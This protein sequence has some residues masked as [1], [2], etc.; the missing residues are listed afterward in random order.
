MIFGMIHSNQALIILALLTI[1]M[2]VNVRYMYSVLI[3]FY[4]FDWFPSEEITAW[5]FEFTSTPSLNQAFEE[6]DYE[7]S[8]IDNLGSVFYWII[9]EV[10]YLALTSALWLCAMRNKI[11]SKVYLTWSKRL[12]YSLWIL[13]IL[14]NY[15]ELHLSCLL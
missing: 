14:E 7:G 15:T 6:M 4:T 13:F 11:L 1:D 10:L 12:T 9:F 3:T 5:L 2:P 8:L